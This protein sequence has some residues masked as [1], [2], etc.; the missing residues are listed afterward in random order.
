MNRKWWP[1]PIAVAV[2]LAAG[3]WSTRPTGAQP[4]SPQ[5]T[6]DRLAAEARQEYDAARERYR[7]ARAAEEAAL[8]QDERDFRALFPPH[9]W[10]D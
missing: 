4:E 8:P 7:A 10:R 3:R 6:L 5:Q 2:G 9:L 1:L